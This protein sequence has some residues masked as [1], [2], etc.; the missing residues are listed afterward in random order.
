[1]AVIF[2]SKPQLTR[3][4]AAAPNSI[5]EVN[6]IGQTPLHLSG[7][8]PTGL[9]L[10]LLAGADV[11]AVD[12]Y[13][14]IPIMCTVRTANVEALQILADAGSPIYTIESSDLLSRATRLERQ[15]YE[16]RGGLSM[17][18][19]AKYTDAVITLLAQRRRQLE[20]FARASLSKRDI[21]NLSLSKDRVIDGCVA[22]C[23]SALKSQEIAIPIEYLRDDEYSLGTTVYHLLWITPRIMET[24]WQAGFRDVDYLDYRGLTPLMT[25]SFLTPNEYLE[26]IQWLISKGA[27][28]YRVDE[29]PG[30]EFPGIDYS[31]F[32][33]DSRIYHAATII[34][35]AFQIGQKLPWDIGIDHKEESKLRKW[36]EGLSIPPKVTLIEIL[37]DKFR[38]TCLCACSPGGCRSITA[39]L[40]SAIPRHNEYYSL[41]PEPFSRSKNDR[42]LSAESFKSMIEWFFVSQLKLFEDDG[43]PSDTLFSEYIRW[44]TF[45]KLELRHTCCRKEQYGYRV[46]VPSLEEI[47]E[48]REEDRDLLEKLEELLDEFETKRQELG[49]S[50]LEFLQGYWRTR[51]DEVLKDSSSLDEDALRRIGVVVHDAELENM[52]DDSDDEEFDD[53]SDEDDTENDSERQNPPSTSI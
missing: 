28:V 18:Q 6:R 48:I 44:K 15:P 3:A 17:K 21:K 30:V 35:V 49:V 53:D 8:W 40:K 1:M 46:C 47:E 50:A 29:V 52:D 12:I 11:N 36:H 25:N 4:V 26:S 16:T 32:R 5:N 37:N 42:L 13:G 27:D 41:Y 45:D 38:D 34:H 2:Q 14:Q 43:A 10:L 20:A 9:R 51:M 33:P 7:D 39:I 24:L 22:Q 31:F 19:R 23:F